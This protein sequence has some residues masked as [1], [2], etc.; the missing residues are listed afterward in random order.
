[1]SNALLPYVHQALSGEPLS[2]E[3]SLTFFNAVVKG[4]VDD[5]LLS[6]VL[7]ALKMRG[8]TPAE[9]A[10]AAQA[11]IN[12]AYN[13]P[14]PDYQ[15]ADIVG[16]G[17]DG[18][19]TINVSSAAAIV[20]ASCGVNVAKHGNRSVSSR[21]GSADLFREYGLNLTMSP[22]TA[23]RCVDESRLSFLFAPNYHKGMRHAMNVRQTIKSRTLFNLLG[24]LAN[25]ARPTHILAGVYAAELVK[26]YA[27][28]L[29]LL[30]YRKAL[31][32]HGA[33]LDEIGLHG[34]TQ[35]SEVNGDS[36]EHYQLHASDFGLQEYPLSGITGG[37]PEENRIMITEVLQGRGEPAHRDSIAANAGALIKLFGKA[38][39]LKESTQMA[40]DS[41][42]SGKPYKTIQ[43]CAQISQ[44]QNRTDTKHISIPEAKLAPKP[45]PKSVS[46]SMTNTPPGNT[47]T[48]PE[49]QA[50]PNILEKIVID[51]RRELVQMKA[52][53]PL[54]SFIDGLTPSDRSLFQA[55]AAPQAGFILECKKA[56]PSK[57]LI[58][59]EFD[60]DEIIMSYAPYAAGISVLT[61]KKYF[62]GD[63]NYLRYV[64]EKVT[65]P[66]LNKDFFVDPYQVHLARYHNADAILLMLSVLSDSEYRELADLAAK[67]QLDVLTEVSNLEEAHRAIALNANIIGINNRNLRDLSTNLATTEELVPIL[68]SPDNGNRLIISESGIYTNQEVHR[69][70]PLVDGFL[71]GSSLMAQPD[72]SCAV[73]RLVQGVVKVCGI[74]RVED[75]FE[76]RSHGARF[77]GLIFAPKSPRCVTP[78]QAKKIVEECSYSYVGVF[79]D[80]D[81]K[82]VCKLAN[83][84]SL[85]AVQ[86]HGNEDQN[87]INALREA[88]PATVQIWKAK[89]IGTDAVRADLPAL[90]EE[91]IDLFLLDCKIGDQSGG[92][93]K[94]FNWR[95]LSEM[96]D[97][98]KLIL[99]GGIRPS[100]ISKAM[101]TGVGIID[102]NS[103]VESAPG[104]KDKHL[105]Q[106][107][108]AA[109]REY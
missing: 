80:A 52:E 101:A 108:F 78:E 25:P 27:E 20:A 75:A 38:T 68:T 58:R 47:Q 96:P 79:V 13:F 70:A 83:D 15:F 32:V 9:I 63:F 82:Q 42:A 104:I 41:M 100:N 22:N 57:G 1:M 60:L 59:D 67:Y 51:K 65:Q 36:I 5:I 99:A 92:T 56:S 11:L 19:N 35:V 64:R 29:L 34:I 71:V 85:H 55:L 10:G 8:E 14:R 103:G 62:Q 98:N 95:L 21:S 40:L 89:S 30:G 90:T 45:Q 87:Y 74:T 23:R 86:L 105:L 39:T 81:I 46:N 106:E 37:E 84:L 28:T 91:H 66:V 17:G 49:T 50:K 54:N 107:A 43:Y 31:V 73:K 18:H 24:P 88:L 33:G 109:L 76:V 69:L 2:Q 72:L 4:E 53:L 3:E 97:K 48:A 6:S 26:S 61:D 12:N 102:I 7:T 16:T 44:G 94:Q 93:G 77:C